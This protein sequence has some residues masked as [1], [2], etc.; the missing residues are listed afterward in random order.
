MAAA[1]QKQRALP[2]EKLNV[3]QGDL[4]QLDDILVVGI[5]L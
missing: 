3:W 5:K 1:M 4:E 2:G